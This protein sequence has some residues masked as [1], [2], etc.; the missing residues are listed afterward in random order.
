MELS[1]LCSDRDTNRGHALSPT[2]EVKNAAR[3]TVSTIRAIKERNKNVCL[4]GGGW[5]VV[6]FTAFLAL[7]CAQQHIRQLREISMLA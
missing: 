7:Q 2:S 6:T 5:E 4:G 1:I 3:L